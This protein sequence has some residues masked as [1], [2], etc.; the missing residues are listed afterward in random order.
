MD[1]AY[2]LFAQTI[3]KAARDLNCSWCAYRE[4]GRYWARFG[5]VLLVVK[6]GDEVVAY[7]VQDVDGVLAEASYLRKDVKMSWFIAESVIKLAKF[8]SEGSV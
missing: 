3:A 4:E 2:N 8:A 7:V 6:I 5:S 1:L